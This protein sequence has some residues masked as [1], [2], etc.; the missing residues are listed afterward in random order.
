MREG[1]LQILL[2]LVN[3][4][5]QDRMYQFSSDFIEIM[6][7]CVSSSSL[8]LPSSIL[9][10]MLR[11]QSACLLN[12]VP[13]SIQSTMKSL[14]CR[15]RV[16]WDL[17]QDEIIGSCRTGDIIGNSQTLLSCRLQGPEVPGAE[18]RFYWTDDRID[19]RLD[20]PHRLC[21]TCDIPWRFHGWR[22]ASERKVRIA[23]GLFI[24]HIVEGRSLE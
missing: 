6:A 16:S 9:P 4:G 1:N 3:L 11:Q 18:S 19:D 22:A 12:A 23:S 14:D 10:G 8:C 2:G 17:G 24:C 21:V 13:H 20:K 7:R 5:L 15:I